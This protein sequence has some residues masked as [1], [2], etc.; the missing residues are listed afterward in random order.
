MQIPH[1]G[2]LVRVRGAR[3]RI[4]Q[5]RAFDDCQVVTLCGLAPPHLGVE[6]RVLAPFD[7]IEPI[8][9][10]PRPRIVRATRWRRACRA[11]IAADGPPGSLRTARSARIDLLP[12]QLEPAIAILRGL[13]TRLAMT[14]RV[15]PR[16]KQPSNSSKTTRVLTRPVCDEWGLYDPEQAGF[17]A[18]MRRLLPNEDDDAKRASSLPVG[19]ATSTRQP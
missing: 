8:A 6:R 5:I 7:T 1:S 11:L 9:R 4:V 3:W 19:G 14:A 18:I 10:A 12:H 15:N 2:D 16:A 13:G 17:E